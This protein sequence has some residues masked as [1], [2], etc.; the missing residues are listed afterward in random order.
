MQITQLGKFIGVLHRQFQ[1]AISHELTLT[2]LNATNANFLLFISEHDRVTAKQISTALAINK[3]LVS[4]EMTRL[5]TTGYIA[6]QPDD[7]DHRTVWITI[8]QKGLTACQTVQKIMLGLWQQVLA[9][10][11]QEGVTAT[12]DHLAEWVD[13]ANELN[14]K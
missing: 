12:Y 2:G 11:P 5:E 4:R 13:R 7:Q 3:G 10:T 9:T 6:R 8:T 1:T 14:Q